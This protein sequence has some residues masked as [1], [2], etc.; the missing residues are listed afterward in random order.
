M[1]NSKFSR[2]I[3]ILILFASFNVITFAKDSTQTK[4]V[5][6]KSSEENVYLGKHA[7]G[8]GS[9]NVAAEYFSKAFELN[10]SDEQAA[11]SAAS[12]YARSGKTD[13]AF[14]WL[15]LAKKA[16]F[17]NVTRIK[18]DHDL[19]SLHSDSRWPVL[20]ASMQSEVNR[21]KR[22]WNSEVWNSRYS[23]QIS[24]DERVAGLSKFWSE[25]KY[26]FVFTDK[27]IELDWDKVYLSYLPK[28]RAAS[29]TFE[30]YKLLMEMCALLKDG[31]TNVYPPDEIY[32]QFITKTLLKTRLIENRIIIEAVG[33]IDLIQ[34][35][36][37][38]GVE[39]V[40]INSIPAKEYVHTK[41]PYT[42]AGTTQDLDVRLFNYEFLVGNI[43]ETVKLG[44]TDENG[45]SFTVEVNRVSY[46]KLNNASFVPNPSNNAYDFSILDGDIAWIRLKT[47]SS[48]Y[49]VE[50]FLKDFK[51]INQAKGI[52]LDVRDNDGGSSDVG[53]EILRTLVNKP[54]QLP[55]SSTRDYKPYLRTRGQAVKRYYF[56]HITLSPNLTNQYKGKI[57]L[58]TSARTFSAAEDFVITFKHMKRG[59]VIG[60][61]SAGSTG[62][63]LKFSLPGGGTARVCTKED[64]SPDGSRFVGIGILPDI[65]VQPSVS[66]VRNNVDSVLKVAINELKRLP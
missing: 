43:N 56:P 51:K 58:L 61:K 11:Y 7:V 47:F 32:D 30:Y 25:I 15:E 14:Q 44:L 38:R 41:S 16:N 49:V 3:A 59:L 6:A 37:V 40:T 1:A 53:F 20:L 57:V 52:I 54:L 23:E 46:E 45:K 36:L 26:N 17:L 10:N 39:I 18:Q 62:Q 21:Q 12:A 24:E 50:A 64:V 65:N 29:N 4:V 35:G 19:K 27:L 2:N 63:P 55:H 9:F 34:K 22:L 13:D 31:H 66:D 8:I 42:I 48:N 33:D 28:V 60:E 5:Y